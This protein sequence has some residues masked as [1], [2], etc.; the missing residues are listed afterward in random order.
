[1]SIVTH[2]D[3][4]DGLLALDPGEIAGVLDV[5]VRR[6][7]SAP[8]PA[9]SV[10]GGPWLT[11]EVAVDQ[12]AA[13]AGYVPVAWRMSPLASSQHQPACLGRHL[14]SRRRSWDGFRRPQAIPRVEAAPGASQAP[15]RGSVR[16]TP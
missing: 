8:A 4:S 1:M 2:G 5:P 16:N 7:A 12:V 11:L 13:A 15:S 10:R 3:I 14:A 9:W 6:C